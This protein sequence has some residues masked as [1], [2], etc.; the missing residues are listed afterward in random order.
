MA[1]AIV[2]GGLSVGDM[3][4]LNIRERAPELVTLRSVGWRESHL[5]RLVALEGLG[6]GLLG[7]LGG[8]GVG[9]G[10]TLLVGGPALELA[11]AG[12]LS[13]LVGVLVAI[14]GSLVPVSLIG[15]MTPAAVL[16]EE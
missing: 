2:L 9:I 12:L 8:V 4:F 7:S 16:A 15:R 3:L 1:S 11:V 6:I 14:I 5:A 10:L 13:G